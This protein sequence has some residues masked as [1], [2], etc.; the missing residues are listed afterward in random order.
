MPTVAHKIPLG[1]SQLFLLDSGTMILL[2]ICLP[3]KWV[4]SHDIFESTPLL[5]C[6]VGMIENQAVKRSGYFGK[7]YR[8]LQ[9]NEIYIGL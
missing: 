7:A 2:F 3:R 5:R 1:T 6:R 8:W 9:I 4:G